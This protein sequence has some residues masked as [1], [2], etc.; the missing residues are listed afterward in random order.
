[1]IADEI[2]GHSGDRNC[3]GVSQPAATGFAG[4]AA[5]AACSTGAATTLAAG[6][7]RTYALASWAAKSEAALAPGSATA[8]N[9][10]VGVER[11]FSG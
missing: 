2:H 5:F 6:A 8:T 3:S 7:R 10:A 4:R 9:G 11:A 1:M